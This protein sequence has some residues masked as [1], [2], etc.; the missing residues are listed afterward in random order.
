MN[1]LVR[2]NA[3]ILAAG[4]LA[5]ACLL[6]WPA[7]IAFGEPAAAAATPVKREPL[8]PKPVAPRSAAAVDAAI[9]RGIQFLLHDQNKNGSWGSAEHTKGLN[10]YAPVPGAHHAFRAAVTSL[11]IMALI[12]S[13]DK[14]AEVEQSLDRGEKW[15]FENLPHLRRATPDALYNVWGHAYSIQAL[16]RMHA[17]KPDDVQRKAKIVDLIKSQLGFLERYEAVNGGWGYY[18]FSAHTQRPAALNSS[19]ITSTGLIAMYEAKQ[20]GIVP[21]EKVVKRAFDSVKRQQKPDF[22]YLYGEDLRWSPAA[23]INL[24]GGSLGRS[25]ACNLAMHLWGD[26]RVTDEVMGTWLDRLWARNLWLDMGRKRPVPHSSHFAVAGY[27]YFYGHYYAALVVEQLPSDQRDSHRDQLAA[28]LLKLQEKDG[29]WWDYPLYNYHQQY[30]T[31]FAIMS[32]VHCRGG[33]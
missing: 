20:I 33:K 15:L 14:S 21:S 26:P 8:K 6:V 3:L 13:G 17:R 24:P 19:F 22:S 11:C 31:A 27:F 32:L 16:V 23:V 29:T 28:R 5:W 9:H 2:R 25:Q 4:G 1:A 10:I 12:E 7:R 30:G 18:D